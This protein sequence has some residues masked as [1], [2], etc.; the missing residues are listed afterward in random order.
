MSTD[1]WMKP[2]LLEE[3]PAKSTQKGPRWIQTQGH[4]GVSA[5]H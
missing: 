5:N 3:S 1:S 4:F 2:E